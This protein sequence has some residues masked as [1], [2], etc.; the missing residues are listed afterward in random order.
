MGWWVTNCAVPLRMLQIRMQHLDQRRR[1]WRDLL[2]VELRPH[3]HL[4]RGSLLQPGPVLYRAGLPARL[5]S[6]PDLERRQCAAAER[7]GG[8]ENCLPL[9][10]TPSPNTPMPPPPISTS[11]PYYPHAVHMSHQN[12]SFT[13]IPWFRRVTLWTSRAMNPPPPFP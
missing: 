3:Q 8:G 2:A 10:T 12:V 13:L 5:H 6:L 11:S 1:R 9:S 4:N 7:L